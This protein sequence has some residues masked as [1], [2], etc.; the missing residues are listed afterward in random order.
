MIAVLELDRGA[1][2]RRAGRDGAGHFRVAPQPARQSPRSADAHRKCTH[3]FPSS[4]SERKRKARAMPP[5]QRTG[6][7]FGVAVES[8]R[9]CGRRQHVVSTPPVEQN[10]PAAAW[11]PNAGYFCNVAQPD[12]SSTADEHHDRRQDS[13]WL[14]PC[15]G[16]R[17]HQ[18]CP[19]RANGSGDDHATPVVQQ[20]VERLL[21]W[22]SPAAIPS[23]CAAASSR[24]AAP[25]CRSAASAPD[26]LRREPT[27]ARARRA[28]RARIA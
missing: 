14:P 12:S 8:E 28:H 2:N 11:L 9:A 20:V 10:E 7:A 22:R 18:E 24:R 27:R 5:P 13:H 26:R 25:A 1:R 3:R 19:D 16:D 4:T 23:P 6:S 15:T 17:K 21:E